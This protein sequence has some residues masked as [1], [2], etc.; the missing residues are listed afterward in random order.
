MD[1]K[2]DTTNDVDTTAQNMNIDIR[3]F[4]LVVGEILPPEI[5]SKIRVVDKTRGGIP[6]RYFTYSGSKISSPRYLIVVNP[7]K[8]SN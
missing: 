8:T 2:F 4:L 7:F 5:A 1:L 3:I 6:H